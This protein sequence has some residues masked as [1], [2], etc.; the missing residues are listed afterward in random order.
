M[1]PKECFCSRQ[2]QDRFADDCSQQCQDLQMTE[3]LRNEPV[4]NS[5]FESKQCVVR[6][7]IRGVCANLSQNAWKIIMQSFVSGV[8]FF[9]FLFTVSLQALLTLLEAD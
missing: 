7:I 4:Q 2:R 5:S 1:L 9:F 3:N 8:I 6:E